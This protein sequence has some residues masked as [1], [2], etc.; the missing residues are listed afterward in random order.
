M[1][2]TR[3][4]PPVWEDDNSKSANPSL[5]PSELPTNFRWG[6]GM[7]ENDENQSDNSS[8]GSFAE[9]RSTP[10]SWGLNGIFRMMDSPK[11]GQTP[12]SGAIRPPAIATAAIE[13]QD[14]GEPRPMSVC[15]DAS[16][17]EM[18]K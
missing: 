7:K 18:N 3:S 12:T 10:Q 16:T 6:S 5:K 9:D 15:M 2:S 11:K 4:S 14:S 17:T 13:E 1:R 8:D